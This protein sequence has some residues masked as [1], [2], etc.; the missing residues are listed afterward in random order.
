MALPPELGFVS[1]VHRPPAVNDDAGA[2]VSL[3]NSSRKDPVGQVRGASAGCGA[4]V[5]V[6]RSWVAV[7]AL[8][9]LVQSPELKPCTLALLDEVRAG[10]LED[11]GQVR[12]VAARGEP[13]DHVVVER[14]RLAEGGVAAVDAGD[15]LAVEAAA[16]GDQV[17]R[18]V[19]DA[20]VGV[21]AAVVGVAE[22]CRRPTARWSS[23][24]AGRTRRVAEVAE[25][26]AR[27]VL[28]ERPARRPSRPRVA[29]WSTISPMMSAS[30]SLIAPDWPQ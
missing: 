11:V 5:G 30:D 25:R 1:R 8:A 20:A 14:R 17:R 29:R 26:A 16:L 28:A 10:L 15:R 6:V 18:L 2:P 13:H 22:R 19:A 23:G 4:L 3:S 27:E 12:V 21:D 24:R 9:T 7:T